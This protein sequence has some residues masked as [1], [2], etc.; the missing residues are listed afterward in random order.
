VQKAAVEEMLQT[1]VRVQTELQG[2]LKQLNSMPESAPAPPPDQQRSQSL[3]VIR[4]VQS[5]TQIHAPVLAIFAD[6]HAMGLKDAKAEAEAEAADVKEATAQAKAMEKVVPT[7]KIVPLAHAQHRLRVQQ[8]GRA[9]R[10]ERLDGESAVRKS[11]SLRWARSGMW[12]QDRSLAWRPT[13]WTI[14]V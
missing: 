7:A 13:S 9:A 4:G 12:V 10:D 3:A 5:F 6:P 2:H 11:R 14:L 1:I 8:R